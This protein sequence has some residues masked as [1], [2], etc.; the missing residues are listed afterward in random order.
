MGSSKANNSQVSRYLV[1][2]TFLAD[3]APSSRYSHSSSRSAEA[4]RP[5][6][7]ISRGHYR[8]RYQA[9]AGVVSEVLALALYT[10]G[11]QKHRDFEIAQVILVPDVAKVV[12]AKERGERMRTTRRRSWNC[13]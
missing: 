9:K 6:L 13:T 7:T 1:S 11:S 4:S 12:A 2:S 10:Y 8:P 3:I 5:V